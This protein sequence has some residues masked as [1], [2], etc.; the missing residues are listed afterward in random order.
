[1]MMHTSG[2]VVRLVVTAALVLPF[3][4]GS[5]PA[6]ALPDAAQPRTGSD[7]GS[8]IGSGRVPPAP[9]RATSIPQRYTVM[10]DDALVSRGQVP[11]LT[12]VLSARYNVVSEGTYL[13]AMRGFQF[14]GTA[15]E[16]ADLSEDYRVAIVS[17][18]QL[19]YALGW[20]SAPLQQTNPP[21][22]GLDRI[23]QASLPLNKRYVFPDEGEGVTAYVIDSGIRASHREFGG[24]AVAGRDFT[25]DRVN[26]DCAGHGTHVAGTIGGATV[27]VAKRVRLVALRVLNCNGVGAISGILSALD[28]VAKNARPPAVVN[29][30]LGHIGTDPALV[31]SIENLTKRN[32][33]VVVA[34]G[35][36]S[37]DACGVSPAESLDALTVSA[38]TQQDSRDIQYANFGPCV[39]I[40]APGTRIYSAWP[41][42]NTSYRTM[43]GTSM[44]TPHVAGAIALLLAEQ[45]RLTP[46]QVAGCMRQKATLNKVANARN[47]PNQLLRVISKC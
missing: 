9:F 29:M 37:G 43:S 32:I 14:E 15:Q 41:D 6:A 17:P 10:Y 23:D 11:G 33:N 26:R 22:W 40:F 1:M 19:V 13:N 34:A 47:S 31:A 12:R 30:S 3:I 36:N 7:S 24:R 45:P 5:S 2:R 42:S 18:D 44:A 8:G 28:W 20:Q 46:Q 16:A 38:T 25:G 4:V 39:N 27:G 21:S 35:N